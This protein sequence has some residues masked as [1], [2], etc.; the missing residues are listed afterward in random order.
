M[1]LVC[2]FF[3]EPRLSYFLLGPGGTGKS[4]WLK[5]NHPG[6]MGVDLLREDVFRICPADWLFGILRMQ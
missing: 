1:G 2:R 3:D 6:A 5:Q 4:T